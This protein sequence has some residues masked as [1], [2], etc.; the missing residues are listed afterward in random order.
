MSKLIYKKMSEIM[1]DI[2]PITKDQ[3]NDMQNFKFRGV[4]QFINALHPVLVKHQVFMV[5]EC[6]SE[7]HEIRDVERN[8]GKRGVDKHAHVM[9]RYHFFA[10][11]GSSI[12]VGPVPG[13]G[14][15]SGDKAT[16]KALSSALKYMLIQ[17]YN[18]PTQDLVDGDSE[19]PEMSTFKTNKSA[20]VAPTVNTTQSNGVS[21]WK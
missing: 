15:D 6:V 16:N 14:L 7:S 20:S 8:N 18:I 2:G 12:T 17:T 21:K 19:S 10:E 11:D 9:M 4:D 1:R 13:E 5:P 3:K